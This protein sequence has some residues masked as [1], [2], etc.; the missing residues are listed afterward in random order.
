VDSLFA[1][2]NA[3]QREAVAHIDGPMLVLAGPGSGKTRVI[4]HRIAN[5]LRQG[6]RPHQIVALTFT[7]R[8]ADEMRLRVNQLA[9]SARVWL[10]TFHRF[11]ARLLRQYAPLMGLDPNYTIYDTAD[12][13]QALKQVLDQIDIPLQHYTAEQLAGV[14]SRAKNNLVAPEDYGRDPRTPIE[15]IIS[16]V[17]PAYARRLL[18]SSAVDFD[19]LLYHIAR[20]LRDHAEVRAELDDRYRY[21][22]VDEYQDT[23]LAQYG[24]VRALSIDWPNLAVT[25]DPDQSIYSWRGANLSNILEFE[26]DFPTARV[27]RLEQN[28]R[29]TQ[30]ILHVAD[31]LIR[32]NVRRKHKEL[33]CDNEPGAPVRLIQ[34]PTHKDE[35]AAIA[36]RVA[37]DIRQGRRRPRDFAVFYRINALSRTFEDAFRAEG[38][39]YQIVN[40]VEFYQRKEIKDVLAYLQLLHNPKNDVALE[41]VIN[42]PSRGIGKTTLARIAEHAQRYELT[43]LEACRESGLIESLGKRPLLAVARFVSLYDRLM[44][45]SHDSALAAV[46]AVLEET[47]YRQ[48][49]AES[50]SED[51]QD[52]LANIEELRTAARE[53]DERHPYPGALEE[54]LEQSSL[55]NDTDN[56]ET[57]IDRATLLTL[58]ASKGLEFPVVFL[59]A[60]EEGI[61]P[62]SRVR[63]FPD[64]LEEERRLAF[65]GITRAREELQ[66]SLASQR[67]FRGQR[68]Y[69]IPSSFIQQLPLEAMEV[70]MRRSTPT[71]PFESP[72][73]VAP[74]P[75]LPLPSNPA[76]LLTTAAQLGGAERPRRPTVSPELFEQGMTVEHPE[77]GRGEI[78]DITGSGT[79]RCATVRFDSVAGP[80]KFILMHSVLRPVS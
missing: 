16:H 5:L 57:E 20:L 14:I 1:H 25:G 2:L 33:Y 54:F 63:D 21:I 64:Q 12:S 46:D 71:I 62:H 9:P 27:I 36:A 11:C 78:V 72:P 7:N 38:I 8:A 66:L 65:V 24:I 47:G 58:H 50:T 3:A 17:Y 48:A 41:R 74:A 79:L 56:W 19:D 10:S 52:R 40:G 29:S 59:V 31:A 15:Q 22:L 42:T 26:R 73:R 77:Y 44:V 67:E 60:C 6:V 34:Y 18:D 35:A 75:A 23:N 37:D 51:D 53:F 70:E 30:R 43:M 61:L 4:T 49:L 32:H 80:K 39:P 68:G 28:Y 13:L 76:A 55:V 69:T 45:A